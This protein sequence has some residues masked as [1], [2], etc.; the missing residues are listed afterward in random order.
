M[1]RLW[2][3]SQISED[4]YRYESD[5]QTLLLLICYTFMTIH[6][7]LFENVKLMIVQKELHP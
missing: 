6:I 2:Q 1:S 7:I 4:L 5:N 3:S